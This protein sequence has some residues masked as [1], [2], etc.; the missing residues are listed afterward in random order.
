MSK[1]HTPG[2]WKVCKRYKG[3]DASETYFDAEGDAGS[4]IFTLLCGTSR[5]DANAKLIAAAPELLDALVTCPD[6]P[7]DFD[8]F[9]EDA[10]EAFRKAFT[11]WQ[12]AAAETI[13][14]AKGL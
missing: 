8:S 4:P 12:T 1:S 3:Q 9:N 6:L 13:A 7:D 14:K 11:T 2:P 10:V 5:R